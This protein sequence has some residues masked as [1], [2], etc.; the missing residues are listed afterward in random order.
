MSNNQSKVLWLEGM[1]LD[2]HHFQ[3]AERHG[4]Q[5]IHSRIRALTPHYWGFQ[6]LEI[7]AGRLTNGE[8]AV[9]KCSGVFSDGYV[10]NLPGDAPLP[11]SRSVAES[12]DA[13]ASSLNV[14]LCL[15]V[16][17]N[18]ANLK[19]P[20]SGESQLTRFQSESLSITDE[21]TGFEDRNI[22]VAI[23]AFHQR[24]CGFF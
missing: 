6:S 10:F 12:F 13:S 3:Q 4:A 2:P 8:I 14:F 24:F 16:Y 23:P 17:R 9:D 18:G 20:G 5:Q 21:N 15:P 22:E 1:T 19:S 7:D 11:A